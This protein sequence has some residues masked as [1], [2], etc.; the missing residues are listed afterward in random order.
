MEGHNLVNSKAAIKEM[1]AKLA[2]G[3]KVHLIV[4]AENIHSLFVF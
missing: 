3:D 1:I 4:Y 2:V